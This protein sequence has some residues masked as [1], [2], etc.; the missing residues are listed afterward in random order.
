MNSWSAVHQHAT[1]SSLSFEPYCSQK[2]PVI[3]RTP[4]QLLFLQRGQP[5]TLIF[6]I[7][8]E[9]CVSIPNVMLVNHVWNFACHLH[10][11]CPY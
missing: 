8:P 1:L 7:S 3:Q 2:Q 5:S 9:K 10:C 4:F 6:P 11:S